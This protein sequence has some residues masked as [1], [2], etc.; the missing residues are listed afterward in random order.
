MCG[1]KFK[2]HR[3]GGWLRTSTWYFVQQSGSEMRFQEY[4]SFLAK[5]I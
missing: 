4:S 3:I 5:N 2:D 1:I